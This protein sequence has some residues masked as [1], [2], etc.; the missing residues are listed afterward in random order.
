VR[1]SLSKNRNKLRLYWTFQGQRY[2]LYLELEDTP[3]NRTV[4]IARQA[5]IE[6][7]LA[8]GNFDPT[9][10]KYKPTV[11]NP[12]IVEI[13]VKF[14]NF[15]AKQCDPQTIE[16]YSALSSH[17]QNY[18]GGSR[19][20]SEATAAKFCEFLSSR[21][22]AA[23]VRERL[24]L[25]KACWD[26]HGLPNP[27][28]SVKLPR[29]RREPQKVP[30]TL[31]EVRSIIELARAKFPHYADFIEFRFRT[32]MRSSEAIGLLWRNV[33][34]ETSQIHISEAVVK[35]DRKRPKTGQ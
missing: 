8:T 29:S 24:G 17:L 6:G 2:F 11:Q 19:L 33:N 20:L 9:L 15:K 18:F 5:Q 7:D 35:G 26:W 23:G 28:L 22:G 10:K 30:F 13:W 16:K 3:L 25:L 12:T 4:A 34:F 14:T 1:V 21:M 31:E 32:G 27:W